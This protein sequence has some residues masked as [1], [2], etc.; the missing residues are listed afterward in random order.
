ME[1]ANMH[2][3]RIPKKFNESKANTNLSSFIMIL[4]WE[5]MKHNI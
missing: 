1:F 4:F 5:P 2:F 3:N